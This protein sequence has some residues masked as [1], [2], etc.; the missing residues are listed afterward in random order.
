[1]GLLTIAERDTLIALLTKLPSIETAA[2]RG[3]LLAGVP[4]SVMQTVQIVNI[5]YVDLSSIVSAADNDGAQQ[6]DGSWPILR[7]ITNASRI[8]PGTKLAGDLQQLLDTAAARAVAPTGTQA[9]VAGTAG[10]TLDTAVLRELLGAAF[11]ASDLTTLAF[12]YFRPVYEDVG[13]G[14]G[15]SQITRALVEYC[16]THGQLEKLVGLVKKA[17]AYQY[18]QF[19]QR[20]Y[21]S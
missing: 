8:V 7:V 1:M 15:K 10:R 16:Q 5:A 11:S 6:A 13:T 9:A 3:V 14:A 17:N 18:G 12:D 2:V 20:L 21:T 19:E 4:Q